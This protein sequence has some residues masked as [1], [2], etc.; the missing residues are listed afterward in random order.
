[1]LSVLSQGGVEMTTN[2]R[3]WRIP[4]HKSTKPMFTVVYICHP[5]SEKT[6]PTS[7]KSSS[8]STIHGKTQASM[9]YMSPCKGVGE[10]EVAAGAGPSNHGGSWFTLLTNKRNIHWHHEI[11]SFPTEIGRDLKN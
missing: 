9:A 8:S 1:M 7:I 2:S 5:S 3:G 10:G 11:T 4:Q 6:E